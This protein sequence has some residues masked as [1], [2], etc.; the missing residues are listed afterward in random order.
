MTIRDMKLNLFKHLLLDAKWFNIFL[1]QM[2]LVWLWWL[3]L[4][5][6]GWYSQK[7]NTQHPLYT[8]HLTLKPSAP[9]W[10]PSRHTSKFW[11]PPCAINKLYGTSSHYEGVPYLVCWTCKFHNQW[12]TFSKAIKVDGANSISFL[13]W[14]PFFGS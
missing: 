5:L 2:F 9:W 4:W 3:V 13:S 7:V 14:T 6:I 1:K 10:V 11:T 8:N 12:C